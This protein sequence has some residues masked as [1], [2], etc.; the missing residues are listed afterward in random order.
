MS[1]DSALSLDISAGHMCVSVS[2]EGRTMIPLLFNLVV[3]PLIHSD[4]C[5][6]IILSLNQLYVGNRKLKTN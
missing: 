5:A 4:I 1:S 6:Q 3:I 2:N